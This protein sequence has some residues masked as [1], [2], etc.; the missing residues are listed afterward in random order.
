MKTLARAHTEE[1]SLTPNFDRVARPY[2]WLEY[3]SFGPMLER[4]RF[5]RLP[6]VAFA[7][8]ALILGDGDGRFTARLLAA[9]PE[10]LIDAVDCS[11][12]MLELLEG[13]ARRLGPEAHARLALSLSDARDFTPP[14]D[15][16]YDLIVTHF[17]L[18]C[19]SHLDLTLLLANLEPAIA[20]GAQWLVSEFQI[21][22]HGL[23]APVS[24]F[25]VSGLY[26]AFGLLT[27]LQTRELPAWE[28]ILERAGFR[29]QDQRSF[30]RG[31]LTSEIWI[32]E[33]GQ[34]NR[35]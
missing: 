20:P 32:R 21:P 29:P 16:R 2:R 28:F 18:D 15:A 27:N 4:V 8:R 7:R 17:F 10:I 5:F 9:N 3:L 19:L 12:R 11:P 1:R 6:E 23:A 33:Q 14:V 26:R 31:L 22:D 30:L 34:G 24:R 13:R 25:I 35:D